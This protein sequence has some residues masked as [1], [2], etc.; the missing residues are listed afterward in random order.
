M[1]WGR[2]SAI[3]RGREQAV[4]PSRPTGYWRALVAVMRESL[5]AYQ[6][7]IAAE[8]AAQRILHQNSECKGVQ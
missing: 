4:K 5:A 8:D 6:R 7:A 3:R 1:P 2:W